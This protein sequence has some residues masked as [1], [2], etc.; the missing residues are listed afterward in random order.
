[1]TKTSVHASDWMSHS[2][3]TKRALAFRAWTRCTSSLVH[4]SMLM[5]FPTG[6]FL[7]WECGRWEKWAGTLRRRSGPSPPTGSLDRGLDHR[8]CCWNRHCGMAAG[9]AGA[10]RRPAWHSRWPG[11]PG[12]LSP[13]KARRW[14]VWAGSWSCAWGRGDRASSRRQSGPARCT[15][16]YSFRSWPRRGGSGYLR[17]TKRQLLER[18]RHLLKAIC[19]Q[20]WCYLKHPMNPTPLLEVFA[21]VAKQSAA[22]AM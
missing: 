15:P 7:V 20:K 12:S 5:S 18:K 14:R 2:L 3:L 13:G 10:R 6:R 11:V 21:A 19:E 9:E 8:C 22:V 4:R 16:S 1:M 17:A